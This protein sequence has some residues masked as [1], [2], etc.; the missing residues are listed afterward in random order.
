[1]CSVLKTN[2]GSFS[3]GREKSVN[4]SGVLKLRSDLTWQHTK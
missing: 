2:R 1:M 4:F 3:F